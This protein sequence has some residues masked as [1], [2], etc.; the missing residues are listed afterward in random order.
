MCGVLQAQDTIRT[1][2]ITEVRLDDA[3]HT[4]VELTN[5]GSTAL[6]LSQFELGTI[7]PW[8]EPWLPP[9]NAWFMLPDRDLEPG[10][11]F[12]VAGVYDW[13][14]RMWL[15]NPDNYSRILNKKEFWSIADIKLH[16]PESPTNDPTDS[17]TPYNAV[18]GLWSGRD[19]LY[20]RHHISA[21]DSVVVDQVN[22][23][24][25][26]DDGTSRDAS[27]DVAGVTHAT[28]EATLIRKFDVEKGNIDFEKGRGQDMTESEWMPIPLQLG[29]WEMMR[30]LFWTVG[31]HGDYNLDGTTLVS[32]TIEIGWADST[33][34]V[35]WGVRNDDSIMN[36]F[37][38]KPGL[39]WHYHYAKSYE[40]SAYISART[41][42]VL[43]IYAAGNDLDMIN[44]RI[45]MAEPTADAKIVI[46]MNVPNEDGFYEGTGP[47]YKVSD[48]IP[49]MDTI[50]GASFRGISFAS[51]VDTLFKYLEKAPLA[52]WE[53]IWVDDQ[54]RTDLKHG[55][56]LKVTAEDGSSKEYFIKVDGYRP[57]HNAFLGSITWPDIPGFYRGQFGWLGDTIPNFDPTLNEYKAQIP[58]EVSN[59]PALIGKAEDVNA[60]V[61]VERARSLTGSVADR[62]IT[63]NT[64][65]EDDTSYMVY[66]ILLEKEKD[67]T[68]LQPWAADPFISQFVWQEQW[69]NTFMEI[70]NPG[71]Q[72]LD[73]SNYM[74]CV[75]YVN[76]PAEAISRLSQPED[77]RYRYGKYIPGYKWVDRA[78]WQA[79]P[80]MAELDLN[81]DPMVKPGDVFVLGEIY[82]WGES[83]YPWWASQQCDIDFG[84]HPWGATDTIPNNSAIRQWSG[85]N[86]YL[87]RIDNDS[88]KRGLKAATDPNDFTLVD[89]FGTGDGSDPVVGGV[90][91][92]QIIGYTR[93][94]NL[95]KGNPEYKG[96]F[97]ADAES[98]EWIMV[99]EAYLNAHNTPWPNN[100][101]FVAQGLGSHFMDDVSLF[102]STVSSYLYKVS[103]GYSDDEL[104]SNIITDTTVAGFLADIVEADTGQILTVK[105]GSTGG[106][107]ALTDTLMNGDTLIV[108][109]ADLKNITKY[110]L[111]VSDEGLSDDALLVSTEYTITA[112]GEEGTVGGFDYGTTLKTVIENVTVPEGA[113]FNVIDENGAF[114]SLKVLNF[115]TLY[116]DAQVND[117]MYFEVIAQSRRNKVVYQLTPNATSS[118]AFVTSNVF[119]VDQETSLIDLVPDGTTTLGLL[120]NL[121]PAPGATLR[122]IDKLGYDRMFGNV[123]KDDKLVVTSEDSTTTKTYYLQMLGNANSVAYVLSEVY[124]VDQLSYS[125]SGDITPT[126]EV[127]DFI[128]NLLP[129]PGA[130]VKV[131]DANGVE[132][133]GTLHVGDLLVVTAGDGVTQ[134]TYTIGILTSVDD[135]DRAAVKVYPNPATDKFSISGLQHGDRIRVN[136]VLGAL[137]LDRNAQQDIEVIQMRGQRNGMYF[138]TVSN[139]DKVIGRYKLILK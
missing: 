58:F 124:T 123:V 33:L 18:L 86:W 94:P 103:E 92:H 17:I 127:S 30:T 74:I 135:P 110:V 128:D 61:E 109:S 83:G 50:E 138:I 65:A 14:P 84:H 13:T 108:Q 76:T 133:T 104:I 125:I 19:C 55:D 32:N 8:T 134:V 16:F 67:S 72:S 63:F 107:L 4:Y 31:N 131:T 95:Y 88:I 15:K 27:H 96:S 26:E 81:V 20:I 87:F 21:T 98:S 132:N 106:I 114:V 34:L 64:T 139:N 78:T 12:V 39:A 36:Q 2:I 112:E 35:P 9:S 5:V 23:I 29:H 75:G 57:S 25:D 53:I 68:N 119:I 100:W 73:M 1:L 46:P 56:I 130:S 47:L 70:A 85:A 115:D 43:T 117:K 99:D 52:S 116:V 79:E 60:K 3:R 71:N 137:V 37:E 90:A 122:I 91:I 44:F 66:K 41:G 51:R 59:V 22:G 24:F 38:K 102:K 77:W 82:A 54:V 42:D 118:D 6:N 121:I 97:G 126:T 101:L 49:G 80:A 10:E 69:Q 113:I 45:E 136:N 105:S 11:S 93:K 111:E 89:V 48:G 28:N 40:D 62:T 129:A 120:S 7:S